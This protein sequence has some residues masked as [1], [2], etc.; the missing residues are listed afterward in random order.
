MCSQNAYDIAAK[1]HAAIARAVARPEVRKLFIERHVVPHCGTPQELDQMI[2]DDL[3]Q[4]G[5][6]VKKADIKA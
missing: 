6:V 5:V 1:L 2:R 3:E 4:W